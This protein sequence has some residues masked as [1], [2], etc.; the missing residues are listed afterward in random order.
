MELGIDVGHIEAVAQIGP[1]H[2]VSGMRQRLG[3]SG[4]RPGQAAVMRV[5]ITEMAMDERIHPLDAMRP[6]TVQAIAMLNLMLRKWNEP[7]LPGRLHLSTLVQQV[8]A[9]IA[10]HGGLTAKQGWDT[11][12]RQRRLHRHRPGALHGCPAAHGASGGAAH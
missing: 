11:A 2:T 8:L 7:P 10:Q 12:G 4:R 1:G 6:T 9:L 5:Y 3:R